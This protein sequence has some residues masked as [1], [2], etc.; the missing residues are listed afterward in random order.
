M[1]SP[2][3]L[4]CISLASRLHLTCISPASHLLGPVPSEAEQLAL[5]GR[6]GLNASALETAHLDPRL[7]DP[8]ECGVY[9]P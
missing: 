8:E 2:L 5:Q 4:S 1:R 6:R 7:A 9:V 3:H